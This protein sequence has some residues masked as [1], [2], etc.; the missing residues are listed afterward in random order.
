MLGRR[1]S[2]LFIDFEN[3][4]Y[5]CGGRRVVE[6]VDNWLRWLE[7]GK[8]DP[9][10][11]RREFISK[12]IFWVPNF[13]KYRLE[14]AQRK[15]DIHMCRAIRKEKASSADF[16]LTIRA[17]ELRH[18]RKDLKEIIVLSLDSDF[19]SILGH[20]QL[21]NL[22]G[23]GMVDPAATYA[24]S[25]RNIVDITIEKPDFMAAFDYVRERRRWFGGSSKSTPKRGSAP[26]TE[27]VAAP[28]AA[29]VQAQPPAAPPAQ[30]VAKA[31]AAKPQA[32]P[33]AA[34][35]FDADAAATIVCAHAE[36][37]GI[38]YLGRE[39]VRKLLR[40]QPGFM[41]NSRPWADGSYRSM[42]DKIVA[43]DNRLSVEK[44]GDNGGFV[45]LYR[46]NASQGGAQQAA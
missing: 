25:F 2:A 36:Q 42:L 3:L 10:G 39:L 34:A 24:Q 43:C 30:P 45:L 13:E 46:S 44:V 21:H 14:F 19:V 31:Q 15:F 28:P 1:K 27:F 4:H 5:C 8:F 41:V 29:E 23:V 33:S 12:Q 11:V 18:A 37:N 16:D 6:S 40:K 26:K 7:D 35:K 17:A 20:V 22:F 38:L 32:T 9:E